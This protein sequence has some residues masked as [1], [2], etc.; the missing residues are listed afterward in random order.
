MVD[1]QGDP[2]HGGDLQKEQ[3]KREIS[4]LYHEVIELCGLGN[5]SDRLSVEYQNTVRDISDTSK[6]DRVRRFLIDAFQQNLE[7]AVESGTAGQDFEIVQVGMLVINS[8]LRFETGFINQALIV[9]D[10]DEIYQ[11]ICISGLKIEQMVVLY[12]KSKELNRYVSK[13]CLP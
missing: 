8:Q 10:L 5:I 12:N 7:Q 9:L 3:E 6:D 11:L 2:S 13:L 4:A 1:G